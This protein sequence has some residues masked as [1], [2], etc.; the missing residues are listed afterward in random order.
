M[1]GLHWYKIHLF[2]HIVAQPV[3]IPRNQT[4][5][6]YMFRITTR[7]HHLCLQDHLTLPP[8]QLAFLAAPLAAC[9]TL[10]AT[11]S[12]P[13][14]DWFVLCPRKQWHGMHSQ[15]M[16]GGWTGGGLVSH[17]GSRSKPHHATKQ[18]ENRLGPTIIL[19]VVKCLCVR[20]LYVCQH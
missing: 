15:G 2:L 12:L 8:P 18:N 6:V 9:E 11:V 10:P 4:I 5:S 3:E 19:T 14:P 7:G 1:T 16:E 13:L 17:T 20:V